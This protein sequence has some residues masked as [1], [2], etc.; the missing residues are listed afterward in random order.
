MRPS[1]SGF[2]LIELM[3]VVA[4]IGILAA[5]AIPQFSEYRARANDS[6]AQADVRNAIWIMSS[7]INN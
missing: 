7:S 2:T 6:N 5:L 1:I 3:I 4:I